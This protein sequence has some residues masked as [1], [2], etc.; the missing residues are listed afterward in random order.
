MNI[1]IGTILFLFVLIFGL[2]PWGGYWYYY[3]IS[4]STHTTYKYEIW[5]GFL[6]MLC[7]LLLILL[8]WGIYKISGIILFKI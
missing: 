4:D 6:L 5:R 8:G 7:G 2:L 1:T 3:D